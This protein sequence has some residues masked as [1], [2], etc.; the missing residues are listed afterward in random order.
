MNSGTRLYD[1][2]F[3]YAELYDD[4]ETPFERFAALWCEGR[5]PRATA[6]LLGADLTSARPCTLTQIGEDLH[7]QPGDGVILAGPAGGWSLVIQVE[8]HNAVLEDSLMRLSR[9]GHRA[10][11]VSWDIGGNE[12]IGYAADGELM[13]RLSF[14]FPESRT[15]AD[16]TVL[17]PVMN[18]LRFRLDE[19]GESI[20]ESIS[21]AFVLAGRLTGEEINADWLDSRHERFVIPRTR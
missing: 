17:D 1:L 3:S 15:G 13:V 14:T 6:A 4:E 21:S 19:N 16:V 5:D 8:G 9:D 10:L 12:E 18:G 2:L 7:V 20:E 11:S